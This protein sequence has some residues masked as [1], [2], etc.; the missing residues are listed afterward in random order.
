MPVWSGTLP[1]LTIDGERVDGEA[2]SFAVIDPSTA[3]A[4]GRAPACSP[5]QL[6]AAFEAA[7]TAWP[8]WAADEAERGRLLH[9]AADHLADHAEEIAAL[10]IRE[11][12]KPAAWASRETA[13]LAP[14]L[15]WFADASLDPEI[16]QD[17][18]QLRVEVHRRPVGVVAA[19]TPWNFP[20]GL[21]MWKMAPAL[22]AGNSVVLKP[23][24]ETPMSSLRLGEILNDI[25]PPGVVNVVA[26][27]D[28]LGEAM[29][30]HPT[31]RKVSFT[32]SVDAGRKVNT[33]SAP[34]LKRVTLELGGNDAAI[35]LDDVD[36]SAVARGLF[37]SSFVNS[38]QTCA[39]IK[40]VYVDRRRHDEL[41]DALVAQ[42]EAAPIGDPHDPETQLGPLITKAQ[43]LR[44][45]GLVGAASDGGATIAC[46]GALVD[47]PGWFYPA[48]IMTN[49]ADD[50]AVVAEEQFGPVLPILAYDDLDDAIERANRTTYGL[51]SSIWAGDPERGAALASRLEAGMTWIN[52]HAVSP[53]SQPFGG[54]KASGLGVENGRWGLE[55]FTDIHTITTQ[56]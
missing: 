2:G 16:V 52:T 48:T 44:V 45:G 26:G 39:A 22:R 50:A 15:R 36:I 9:Q 5:D 3:T 8:A 51:G 43:F 55:S 1:R 38:G 6:D 21:S 46:G 24:P 42:A 4:T 27:P 17:D 25:L 54:I 37:W 11:T 34:D 12:G 19:I 53:V 35:V 47:R 23:S 49:V 29:T 31:P 18:E 32:G 40:R 20:V 28:P 33:A 30:A 10:V 56:R 13:G 41:V 14:R 7:H